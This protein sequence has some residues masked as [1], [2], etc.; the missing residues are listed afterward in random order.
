MNY[1]DRKIK[2]AI[3]GCGHIGKRHAEM[4]RRNVEA[5]LVGMCDIRPKDALKLDE[6]KDVPF[7]N[8]ID[9]D[10]E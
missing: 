3:T 4:I 2:F 5:E 1:Q 9:A 6:F 10:A 8:S 7:F